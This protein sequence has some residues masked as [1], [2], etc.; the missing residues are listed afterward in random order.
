M[1]NHAEYLLLAALC[2]SGCHDTINSGIILKKGE[3]PK[4]EEI[5]WTKLGQVYFPYSVNVD[6]SYYIIF[7]KDGQSRYVRLDKSEWE[8]YHLGDKFP[9]LEKINDNNN[10]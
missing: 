4:H 3:I 6:A 5:H 7:S 9:H 2:L 8:G 1:K 10:R